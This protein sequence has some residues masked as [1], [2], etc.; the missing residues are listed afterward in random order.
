[1]VAPRNEVNVALP[2]GRITAEK[3]TNMK[4]GDW[5]SLAGLVVSVAGFSF[6]IWQFVHGMRAPE[7]D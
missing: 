2:F 6:V 3:P 1:V 4:A 5:I 7:A